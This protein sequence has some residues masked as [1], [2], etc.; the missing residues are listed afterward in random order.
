MESIGKQIGKLRQSAGVTQEKLGQALGV[1]TQAVSRWECGGT[2][3][4]SLLPA[5][6]EF[7]QV[8]IDELFGREG[9][10]DG[11]SLEGALE[12]RLAA[13]PEKERYEQAYQ[14][15]NHIRNGILS[16]YMSQQIDILGDDFGDKMGGI[17]VYSSTIMNQCVVWT[18][19]MKDDHSF[20]LMPEPEKGFGSVLD[21]PEEYERLFSMLGKPGRSAVLIYLYGNNDSQSPGFSAQWVSE[22]VGLPLKQVSEILTELTGAEILAC[23]KV[24]VSREEEIEAYS[25]KTGMEMSVLLLLLNARYCIHRPTAFAPLWDERSKPILAG[26]RGR[27]ADVEG[28]DSSLGES[29]SERKTLSGGIGKDGESMRKQMAEGCVG[30]LPSVR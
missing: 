19:V 30:Q 4:A 9:K 22:G 16:E 29:D 1:T 6:A 15:C 21:Q 14:L 28:S 25:L 20:F 18:K 24:R 27:S 26:V 5:I 10:K 17:D 12:R 7:F 11:E 23:Q 2:P 13:C 8:S 3:D